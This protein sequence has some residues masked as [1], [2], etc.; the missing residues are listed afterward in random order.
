MTWS[1]LELVPTDDD[2]QSIIRCVASNVHFPDDSKEQQ[3][4]L[5]VQCTVL[6]FALRALQHLFFF[7][8]RF[9]SK[10][11]SFPVDPPRLQINL[12]RNLNVSNIKEGSDVYFDCSI[13]ASPTIS[14]LDWNHNVSIKKTQDRV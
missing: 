8:Y 3:V 7:F 10:F 9:S 12:G 4:K 1:T 6:T 2:D 5:N 14:R 13:K 11:S